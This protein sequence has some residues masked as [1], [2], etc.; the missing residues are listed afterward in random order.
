[1]ANGPM[2]PKVVEEPEKQTEKENLNRTK[3]SFRR[4]KWI[5]NGVLLARSPVSKDMT[6]AAGVEKLRPSTDR[7]K[8]L[9]LT[10]SAQLKAVP[11]IRLR[12]RLST[13]GG[14][15]SVDKVLRGYETNGEDR[16]PN[17]QVIEKL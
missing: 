6:P 5:S 7:I 4:W 13:A 2:M 17:L 3:K 14:L 12:Q 15:L 9:S 1:M 10:L 16:I 11:L 8:C